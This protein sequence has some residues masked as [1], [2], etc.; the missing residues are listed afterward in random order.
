VKPKAAA[1]AASSTETGRDVVR[2][3]TIVL[4]LLSVLAAVQP[5]SSQER[6]PAKPIK[7]LIPFGPGGAPDIVARVIGDQMRR[8]LGQPFVIEN[9]AG[10]FG[11]VATEEM[12]RSRPD[13]YTLMLGNVATNV[14]TPII[15][16][17]KMTIDYEAAVV[18]IARLT[19]IPS[20]LAIT[21]KIE[22][23]TVAEF[24]AYAKAR[25]GR[26]RYNTTGAGS[27]VH[28]DNVAFARKAG[29]DMVH[30]PVK[31][32]AVQMMNDLMLGDVHVTFLNVATSA[33]QVRSGGVRALAVAADQ[34]LPDFPD[35]PTM[36][37]VGFAGIGTAQWQALFA[38]AGTP[39]PVL[40]TLQR[41]II[42]ALQ[43]PT[44]RE[45]FAKSY[46]R[47]DPT[48][49]LDE[50]RTWLRREMAEWRAALAEIKLDVEE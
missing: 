46:I 32:G 1:R 39:Q 10:A 22:P 12:V 37:E 44:V 16:R 40:A 25:P 11:I 9:K 20:F 17:K 14:M 24:V 27:F 8:I 23:G 45:T 35:V 13:G 15:H 26:I 5:A 19:R 50:A 49:S 30:I 38:P 48:G 21:P 43:T 33:G 34:R 41:A 6:F 3:T 47:I 29:L 31:S 4:G 7:V 28:V 36:A 2:S 18:P 42:E